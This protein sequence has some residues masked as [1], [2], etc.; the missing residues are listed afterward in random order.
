MLAGL[1]EC[2]YTAISSPQVHN[3]LY[4]PEQKE[5]TLCILVLNLLSYLGC[6]DA[7]ILY[8]STI[9]HTLKQ[10]NLRTVL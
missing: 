2:E 3:K 9:Q 7:R 5:E 8:N 10:G 6:L 4:T 1:A